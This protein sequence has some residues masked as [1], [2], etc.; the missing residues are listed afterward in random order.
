MIMLSLR[1]LKVKALRR[2]RKL[3][4]PTPKMNTWGHGWQARRAVVK[5]SKA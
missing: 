3:T 1:Y 5:E 2:Q 4:S